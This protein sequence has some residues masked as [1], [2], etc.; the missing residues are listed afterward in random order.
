MSNFGRLLSDNKRIPIKLLDLAILL[1]HVHKG[2][3]MR[4]TI[5]FGDA[6]RSLLSITK[7]LNKKVWIEPFLIESALWSA[8]C[9]DEINRF[10]H[11]E[12]IPFEEW[13][14][15]LVGKYNA[16]RFWIE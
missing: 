10:W 3:Q 2:A 4:N 7:R 5:G 12:K 16:K 9:L 15:K 8:N 14:N 13:A 11:P 1:F 6:N